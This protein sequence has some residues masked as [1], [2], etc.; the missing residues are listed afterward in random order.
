MYMRACTQN[1]FILSKKCVRFPITPV[2]KQDFVQ[3]LALKLVR[4]CITL[5]VIND[6][7]RM[8]SILYFQ[9]LLF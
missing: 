6:Q 1:M 5:I 9:K 4:S 8:V 2:L 7:N 3:I